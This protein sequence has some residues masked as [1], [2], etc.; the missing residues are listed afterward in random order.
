MSIYWSKS[1]RTSQLQPNSFRWQTNQK[2]RPKNFT[3][4]IILLDIFGLTRAWPFK[5]LVKHLH[6]LYKNICFN[7][8]SCC[9]FWSLHVL[10]TIHFNINIF[11][12]TLGKLICYNIEL[13]FLTD[14]LHIIRFNIHVILVTKALTIFSFSFFFY[15]FFN[16]LKYKCLRY[17][18]HS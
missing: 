11:I 12:T 7:S 6:S 16:N 18:I 4:V 13:N 2:Y 5:I 3:A 8:T 10:F 1:P 9:L 15:F 17:E 14:S